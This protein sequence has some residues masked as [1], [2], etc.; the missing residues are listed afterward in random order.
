MWAVMAGL[1][2]TL[3]ALVMTIGNTGIID[4]FTLGI[5]MAVT[6]MCGLWYFLSSVRGEQ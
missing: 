4:I 6:L 1:S 3:V 2:T 5:V